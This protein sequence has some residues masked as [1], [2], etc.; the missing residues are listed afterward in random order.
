MNKNIEKRVLDIAN[1]I[2]NTEK[3]IREA[4]KQFNVS[5]STVHKDMNERLFILNEKEYRKCI[6][7]ICCSR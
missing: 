6:E 4:A 5:K 2:V 1:Y 7:N 3:T